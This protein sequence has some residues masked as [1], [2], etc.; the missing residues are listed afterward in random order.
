MARTLDEI[1]EAQRLLSQTPVP[2]NMFSTPN[3]GP[4]MGM[5]RSPTQTELIRQA[6]PTLPPPL[7]PSPMTQHMAGMAAGYNNSQLTG[8]AHGLA[9]T[10]GYLDPNNAGS[11]FAQSRMGQTGQSFGRGLSNA[12]MVTGF[13]PGMQMASLGVG[14]AANTIGDWTMNNPLTRGVHSAFYGQA[15]Q[16]LSNMAQVQHGTAGSL[17]LTGASS[18]LSGTGMSA[19]GAMQMGRQFQ[20]MAER[21][22]G[23]NPERAKQAGGGDSSLG[24]KRYTEDLTKLTQMAGDSGL[25]DAAT[26]IDQVSTTVQKLFKVL[27]AMGKITGDPD[28]KNNLRE[29]ASMRQ[30]G[31]TLDQAVTAT[32]DIQRFARGMG[33]SREQMMATG[34]AMGQQA[35]SQAGLVGGMGMV[36]GAHAQLQSRQLAGTFSPMREAMLGGQEGIAARFAQQQ[37]QFASGPMSMMLGAA[38]TAGPG[39][40][41]GVNASQM[42]G[43]LSGGMTI[44]GMAGQSNNNLMQVARQMASSQGISQQ[45][46]L[47]Q[48]QMQM[49]TGELASTVAQQLGPTG[50]KMLQMNTIA[51]LA[52]QTGSLTAASY[53]VSGGDAKQAQMLMGMMTS[54]EAYNRERER[55]QQDR[56]VLQTNA[57]QEAELLRNDRERIRDEHTAGFLGYRA[58]GRAAAT[59]WRST[60]TSTINDF[61]PTQ[62]NQRAADEEVQR[63]R[64]NEDE[65]KGISAAYFKGRGPNEDI[66]RE[67]TAALR[68]RRGLDVETGKG[69]GR[70]ASFRKRVAEDEGYEVSSDQ[71][72]ITQDA[73]GSMNFVVKAGRG[74]IVDYL[75]NDRADFLRGKGKEV[76]LETMEMAQA[77]TDTGEE[78]VRGFAASTRN[79]SEQMTKK[80]LAGASTVYNVEKAILSYAEKIGT[81][82]GTLKADGI[83][84]KVRSELRAAGMKPADIDNALKGKNRN[85]WLRHATR[86]IRSRGT[87]IQ[88]VSL[89]E[90]VDLADQMAK[91]DIEVV[92][93]RIDDAQDK[94]DK[95]LKD[96]GIV[97]SYIFTGG[98]EDAVTAFKG[99]KD[100]DV[101]EVMMLT[102]MAKSDS[103]ASD[104]A[105]TQAGVRLAE[106]TGGS[107]GGALLEKA[108]MELGKITAAGGDVTAI[109]RIGGVVQKY[110]GGVGSLAE[111]VRKGRKGEKGSILAGLWGQ[112][113][114]VTRETDRGYKYEG[115]R[116]VL[117]GRDTGT[118]DTEKQMKVIDA[119][120]ENLSSMQKQ[121]ARFGIATGTL[122]AAA[123]K[124]ETAANIMSGGRT[125]NTLKSWNILANLPIPK[126]G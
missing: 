77:I 12:S 101:Q 88:K 49:Q 13:V 75:D 48:I 44:S 114:A 11:S 92:Q 107:E 99:I 102:E 43:M 38:L 78:G 39:G 55:L 119:Q 14:L 35:F 51:S 58:I 110:T 104:E 26:N 108:T 111:Q 76:I 64:R 27:G 67:R 115:G 100:A 30:S 63:I 36:Y 109:G 83:L 28:F 113:T 117:P 86:V 105:R 52:K 66:V 34:G 103:G 93:K 8:V 50:M 31:Y 19:T 79:L 32:R 80:G 70:Y 72:D 16:S 42:S 10:Q 40:Q 24:I 87:D 123:V 95:M 74:F 47:A 81:D 56:N 37:T 82:G 57:R 54:P 29:L 41:L 60:V 45:E 89:G 68:S 116:I 20:G 96:S 18:G 97:D 84:G 53:A 21:W 62:S 124:L 125:E 121:F 4:D 1:L 3:W 106:L 71:Y 91:E 120:I 25:L 9:A 2:Q 33:M 65:A 85:Y 126:L 98:E 90:T 46:A 61:T 23:Q 15:S 5:T 22:A 17:Q 6:M 73:A 94:Y 122:Q 112:E 59:A 69:M 118:T 7:P